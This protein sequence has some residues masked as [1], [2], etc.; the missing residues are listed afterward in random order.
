MENSRKEKVNKKK[1]SF[2][3]T[4]HK[5]CL[6]SKKERSLRVLLKKKNSCNDG[7]ERFRYS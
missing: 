1:T 2:Y 7:S 4:K 5:I 6:I 3:V